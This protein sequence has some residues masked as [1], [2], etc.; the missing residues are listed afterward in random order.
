MCHP[1]ILGL[2]Y[3]FCQCFVPLRKEFVDCLLETC[4]SSLC[5]PYECVG[6]LCTCTRVWDGEELRVLR[7]EEG[8]C[9]GCWEGD[10]RPFSPQRIYHKRMLSPSLHE[11]SAKYSTMTRTPSSRSPTSASNPAPNQHPGS[12]P[13]TAMRSNNPSPEAMRNLSRAS[14][15]SYASLADYGYS[16][17]PLQPPAPRS[18][19][20]LPSASAS[21]V[22]GRLRGIREVYEGDY[23]VRPPTQ[24][25]QEFVNV[26]EGA[27]DRSQSSGTTVSDER[28]WR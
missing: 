23:D 1:L 3:T 12:R 17:R 16:V 21:V 5:H 26:R 14:G 4:T 20:G 2:K 19:Q 6:Y 11:S 7:W 9:A 18:R 24:L 13:P 10:L 8:V 28:Y 27:A 15:R 25:R 22:G